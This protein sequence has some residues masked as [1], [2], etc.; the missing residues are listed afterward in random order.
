MDSTHY[1]KFDVPSAKRPAVDDTADV[2]PLYITVAAVLLFDI[3]RLVIRMSVRI[4]MSNDVLSKLVMLV[5]SMAI[6]SNGSVMQ[7][8]RRH[9]DC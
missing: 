9:L 5:N 7:S 3:I 4:G 6:H 1:H 8:E 2:V